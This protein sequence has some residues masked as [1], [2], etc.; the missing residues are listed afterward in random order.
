MRKWIEPVTDRSLLD[1]KVRAP[2]AFLHADDLNRIESNIAYLSERIN[3][4]GYNIEAVLP[5]DWRKCA[6]PRV[7]D[8][9]RICDNI[10]K[11]INAYRKPDG[12]TD[13]SDI[14]QK[15]LHITDVNDLERNLLLLLELLESGLSHGFLTR[16]THGELKQY[17]HA[18]IRT[19]GVTSPAS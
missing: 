19:G 4:L 9:E 16:F 7:A 5:T 13:L 18:Q 8:V 6:V 14:P 15:A 2:K 1:I 3:R 17:T 12:Y 11:I 10:L